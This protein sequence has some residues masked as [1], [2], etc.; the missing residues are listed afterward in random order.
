MKK[1]VVVSKMVIPKIRDFVKI[2]NRLFVTFKYKIPTTVI[3]SRKKIIYKYESSL[4]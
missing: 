4:R 2:K 1:T 3:K